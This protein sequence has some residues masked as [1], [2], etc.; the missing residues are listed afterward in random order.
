MSKKIVKPTPSEKAER[1]DKERLK[2]LFRNVGSVGVSAAKKKVTP[3]K[4]KNNWVEKLASDVKAYFKKEK[5]D[6]K[7]KQHDTPRT[8]VVKARLRHTGMTERDIK[9]V[10]GGK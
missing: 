4:E 7:K 10:R 1:P 8:S 3:K 6:K 9:S 5:A 2:Q